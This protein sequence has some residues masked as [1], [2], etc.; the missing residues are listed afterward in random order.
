M[1][2]GK[3]LDHAGQVGKQ[4]F[5]IVVETKKKDVLHES[6]LFFVILIITFKN[7]EDEWRKIEIV[8]RGHVCC[9]TE[10]VK[11]WPKEVVSRSWSPSAGLQSI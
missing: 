6:D 3:W 9:I 2:V 5:C 7:H 4:H 11:W 1:F 8:E 10:V